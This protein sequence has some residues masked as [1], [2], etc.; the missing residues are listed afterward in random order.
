ME[1]VVWNDYL[2]PWAYLGRSRTAL[3]EAEGVLVTHL[4]YELHPNI[5]LQGR[6]L[7]PGGRRAEVYDYIAEQCRDVGLPFNSPAHAPNTH[8]ALLTAEYV[9]THAPH[10]FRVL[11][12]SMFEAVFVHGRDLGDPAVVDE[13]VA[14]A[15]ADPVATRA[16]VE[17]G[18]L[19]EALASSIAQAQDRGVLGTP[20]W[21]LDGR[22][23]IPGVQDPE[24]VRILVER[25]RT[26]PTPAT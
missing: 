24:T 12:D 1:A 8:R 14:T 13:L 26:R 7:Q 4:P 16:A 15:G 5:P 25:A 20:A 2:C 10:C 17:A 9:R 23:L 19:D 21:L 3:I 22:L 6:A 11:D 18:A